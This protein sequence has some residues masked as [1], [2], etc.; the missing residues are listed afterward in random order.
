HE[1]RPHKVRDPAPG[2]LICL[3]RGHRRDGFKASRRLLD[4]AA[5][6]R[7][8]KADTV[9]VMGTEKSTLDELRIDRSTQTD[10]PFPKWLMIVVLFLV[11]AGAVAWGFL[12]SKPVE[13]RTALV[14]DAAGGTGGNGARTVLNASGYVTARRGA[15]A[16]SKVPRKV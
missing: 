12:R 9:M 7:F 13:V 6:R 1:H 8:A 14:R 5:Q 16:S 4:T 11:V 15:P 2:I 3:L 10:K